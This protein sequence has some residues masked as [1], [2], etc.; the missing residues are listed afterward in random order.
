MGNMVTNV[1]VKF[2]YDPL[3]PDKALVNFQKSDNDNK[4]NNN[5]TVVGTLSRQL[6]QQQHA[7]SRRCRKVLHGRQ[8]T[9]TPLRK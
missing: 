3:R 8:M 2:N 1:Y 7:F 4:S 5:N 9:A 6:R